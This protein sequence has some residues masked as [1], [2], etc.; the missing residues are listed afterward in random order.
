MA[1][2]I[3]KKFINMVSGSL[4]KF[5]WK[6]EDLA[7]CRCPICG[8]SSKNKNKAR[9][10]F[11]VK[12]S[13]YFYKC[14]NCGYGCNIYNFL[15]EVSPSLCKEYS[16]EN[17]KEKDNRQKREERET[18]MFNKFVNKKPAF[19]K[20]DKLL[21]GLERLCDLPDD[22]VAVKFANMR[23]I[24]K[25]HWK[26]LY[27]TEDFGSFMKELDSDCLPVGKEERLVIPFFNSHGTVVACQG[28]SLNM[29]EEAE[30]RTTAKYITVKADKSIDR[31]WDGLWRADAN[32][33]VYAVEGPI[34][35]LFLTNSVAMVGAGAL[36]EIPLRF[37]N[38]PMTFVLDNEPRNRQICA[39]IEKL[40][41]MGREVCI[42]PDN[43][44][45]K[46]INDM[47]Y[48]LSTRK[49]Q[50]IIDEN[51]YSGLKATLRFRDWRKV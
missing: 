25:Q 33:R 17:F 31:L 26:L 28:R 2:H 49:I 3:D 16:M 51:T 13:S 48:R 32:K 39:Y 11:F 22:H 9:G 14:H 20:K 15:K 21:D 36:K 19:K 24:P 8:D 5:A 35:S 34:D 27:Y 41:E 6:K 50:R 43:I 45:E 10:Y 4:D 40:I 46:D 12:S 1:L 44:Y 38:T 7:N 30:A 23:V 37:E 47:A 18:D 29:K 42:W